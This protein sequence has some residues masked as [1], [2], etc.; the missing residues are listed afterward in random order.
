MDKVCLEL[1]AHNLYNC[2]LLRDLD[3]LSRSN[4]YCSRF[5]VTKNV[6]I[7]DGCQEIYDPKKNIKE[8]I[9]DLSD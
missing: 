5:F 4:L 6:V 7:D 3:S 9:V 8:E 2:E 1:V